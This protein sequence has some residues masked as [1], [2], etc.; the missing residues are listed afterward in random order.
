VNASTLSLRV[1]GGV[2]AAVLRKS[3]RDV[4]HFEVIEGGGVRE[5]DLVYHP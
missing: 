1:A 3:L 2:D 5:V 4:G